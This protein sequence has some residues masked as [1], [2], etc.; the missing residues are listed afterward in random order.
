MIE[1]FSAGRPQCNRRLSARPKPA[2]GYGIRNRSARPGPFIPA[3]A[4]MTGALMPKSDS[5]EAA[6]SKAFSFSPHLAIP[7]FSVILSRAKNLNSS[8]HC[9]S[10]VLRKRFRPKDFRFFASL[11]MTF[12]DNEKALR[13]R[14]RPLAF[15]HPAYII[16]TI[17]RRKIT[18]NHLARSKQD[19]GGR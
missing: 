10:S 15:P 8:R 16:G 13:R 4:G 7:P 19:L 1:T 2:Q 12:A 17:G 5:P 9:F 14:H 18:G 11:R 3:L 6:A